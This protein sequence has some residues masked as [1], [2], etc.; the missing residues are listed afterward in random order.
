MKSIA[1]LWYFYLFCF[2]IFL[3]LIGGMNYFR[4][5]VNIPFEQIIITV[6][7]Y[8]FYC[9]AISSLIVGAWKSNMGKNSR[10]C[11]DLSFFDLYFYSFYRFFGT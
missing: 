9:V 3:M 5:D 7:L 6:A 4:N 2:L 8:L 10:K 11:H 1:V